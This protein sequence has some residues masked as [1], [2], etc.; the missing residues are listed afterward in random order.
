MAVTRDQYGLRTSLY[1][2]EQ[3]IL[4]DQQS[5]YSLRRVRYT[6]DG[7]LPVQLMWQSVVWN[8]G[9]AVR[10][11]TWKTRVDAVDYALG[12]AAQ[13]GIG[14]KRDRTKAYQKRT[15]GIATCPECGGLDD[16]G[17]QSHTSICSRLGTARSRRRA[18]MT[19][20]K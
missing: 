20:W 16:I 3:F 18:A 13:H 19:G 6:A 4:G 15:G 10:S 12:R 17:Y 7:E 11:D 14:T 2:G 1:R 9:S 8:D 5:G